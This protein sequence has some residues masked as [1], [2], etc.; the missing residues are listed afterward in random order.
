[1][2]LTLQAA[3]RAGV[4]L[5][6]MTGIGIALLAQG[7][8]SNGRST[9][10]VGVIVAAVG[11]LSVIYQI[12]RWSLLRQSIVHFA[13]M[14]VTVLPALFFSGWFPVDTPG[15]ILLVVG[16]FLLT[17]VVLWSIFYLIA[18]AIDKHARSSR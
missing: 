15:R 18:R 4:P 13:I 9:I 5:V 11:G 6:I 10:A 8:E 2:R 16:L 3:L 12:E 17:G 1:M 14:S 7:Q